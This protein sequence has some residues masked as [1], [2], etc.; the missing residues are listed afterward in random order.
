MVAP[1]SWTAAALRRFAGG[2]KMPGHPL[3]GSVV[4]GSKPVDFIPWSAGT[5]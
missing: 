5:A 1:A 2:L 3:P 4:S